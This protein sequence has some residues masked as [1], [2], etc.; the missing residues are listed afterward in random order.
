[1]AKVDRLEAVGS[2][3]PLFDVD[4]R[5][6]DLANNKA[7]L[8]ALDE[9]ASLIQVLFSPIGKR[10]LRE[11]IRHAIS[12]GPWGIVRRAVFQIR[13]TINVAVD[14]RFDRKHCVD[15]CGL[16]IS[17]KVPTS[18][19][20]KKY[21][22]E[23][24]AV[25]AKTF[26]A[27]LDAI[28]GDIGNYSFVDYGCGKG[29]ALLLAAERPFRRVIG[30]E[31]SRPLAEI[32]K[33]NFSTYR[34]APIRCKS[35]EVLHV[36]ATQYVPPTEPAVLFF[37]SPFK[38]SV[39]KRVLD[40]IAQ[41]YFS[42]PRATVILFVEDEDTLPIPVDLFQAT[43]FLQPVEVPPIAFDIG[44]PAPQTYVVWASPEAVAKES[45]KG[46]ARGLGS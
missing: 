19:T 36:D 35:Y 8:S 46:P 33:Q 28:P 34:N 3:L 31:Y 32:A 10:G 11:S 40:R 44:A 27:M 30:V 43:K 6:Q 37:F 39:L 7:E 20:N 29:R 18:S 13:K 26:R 9:P 2:D 45:T 15:T 12:L 5:D 4:N 23:Y 21:G 17:R 41:S 25:A 38:I 22:H 42:S 24:A 1:M 16:I 14:R